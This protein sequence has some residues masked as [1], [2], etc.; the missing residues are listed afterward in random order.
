LDSHEKERRREW[1]ALTI[2]NHAREKVE[3]I[4]TIRASLLPP[5]LTFTLK[6][7]S[8]ST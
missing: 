3:V 5:S 6:E 2:G 8:A 7:E 1:I 4:A